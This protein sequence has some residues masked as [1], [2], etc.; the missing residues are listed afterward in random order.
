MLHLEQ[1]RKF[2]R[3]TYVEKQRVAVGFPVD[4]RQVVGPVTA[5]KS[6]GQ[7]HHS[8]SASHRGAEQQV[9]L[10][11]VRSV[12]WT[13][14]GSWNSEARGRRCTAQASKHVAAG[15][16][17]K[18][19]WQ[20][21]SSGFGHSGNL[22]MLL[23]GPVSQTHQVVDQS[24]RGSDMGAHRVASFHSRWFLSRPI[25]ER[26]LQLR[27]HSHVG[28]AQGRGRVQ[29]LWHFSI[30]PKNGRG[31]SRCV[32]SVEAE[33]FLYTFWSWERNGRGKTSGDSRRASRGTKTTGGVFSPARRRE[34]D[35][36]KGP[37]YVGSLQRRVKSS[38]R[39]RRAVLC[40]KM[41][42]RQKKEAQKWE[43]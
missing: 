13:P 33:T 2:K 41:G 43:S 10:C 12:R 24:S 1:R 35:E 5:G 32:A 25:A 19:R 6:A 11:L 14:R 4:C 17:S 28:T 15:R 39:R 38:Q 26:S 23:G 40:R 36:I 21:H 7:F 27:D 16:T 18:V 22:P 37:S 34:T 20:L 42:A 9:A 8:T 30:P 3:P 31:V 29:N